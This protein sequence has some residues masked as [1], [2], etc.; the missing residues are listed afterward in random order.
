MEHHNAVASPTVAVFDV[1]LPPFCSSD[2]VLWFAQVE[3]QFAARRITADHTKYRHVVANIPPATASE[4]RDILLA[5]PAE[6]AYRVLK[7]TMI[8][9]L[10]TSEPERLQQL[11][12]ET[13]L[14]DRRPSQLLRHMQ[15]LAGCTAGLDSRLVQEL[16]LQRLPATVRI[17]VTASVETNVSKIAEMA[18]R[19]MTVTTPAVA[20]VLAEAS[21]SPALLEIRAEISRLADTVAALQSRGSQST[22][23]SATQQQRQLCWY[24]RKFG[25][26][27]RKCVPPCEK[28]GNAP[29]QH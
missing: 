26:T 21:P 24:H 23:R 8:R 6:D 13:E 25:D 5:P 29:S 16:F 2:P 10:T 17:G 9:R 28:S 18:D 19:L 1:K 27:A 11:L 7:D 22:R 14:G 4:V 20:T 15:Q 12:R 3:S